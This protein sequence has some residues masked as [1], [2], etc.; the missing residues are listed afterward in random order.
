MRYLSRSM[1]AVAAALILSPGAVYAQT[2]QG[3]FVPN[4]GGQSSAKHGTAAPSHTAR[5][6]VAMPDMGPAIPVA[7][8]S[9]PKAEAAA[10]AQASAPIP[11]LPTLMKESPPPAPIIGVIGVPDVLQASTAAQAVQKEIEARRAALTAE[12][13]KEQDMWRRVQAALADPNA[14]YT[15]DDLRKRELALQQRIGNSQLAFRNNEARIQAA[16][17]VSLGQIER[18]LIAVIRQVST[19]RGMNL[20]LHRAQV[21]LNMNEFDITT[22]VTKQL[23]QVLPSVTVP[24]DSAFSKVTAAAMQAQQ[25][26]DQGQ[27]PIGQ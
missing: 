12:V 25:Q 27:G 15:Q 21:A 16:A 11:T 19:S 1:V 18:T 3:W 9:D 14:H 20:V 8:A 5:R 17:Q 10:Q 22:E 4:Q 23:N 13:K 2:S 26:A 6:A 24:P 7:P